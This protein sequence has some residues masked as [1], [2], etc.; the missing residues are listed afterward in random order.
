[1]F[2]LTNYAQVK[3]KCD[4]LYFLKVTE[5]PLTKFNISINSMCVME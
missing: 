2:L 3:I 4:Y 1:M 5:K